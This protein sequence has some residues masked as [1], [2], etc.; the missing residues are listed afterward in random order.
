M[1]HMKRRA[2]TSLIVV[3]LAIFVLCALLIILLTRPA[4]ATELCPPKHY[5]CW[6]VR[7]A[8]ASFGEAALEARARA[9]GWSELQIAVARR[10]IANSA[11][12]PSSTGESR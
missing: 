10:C 7:A 12:R 11:S 8:A 9:C 6:Q 4:R 3:V 5:F 2:T 1:P